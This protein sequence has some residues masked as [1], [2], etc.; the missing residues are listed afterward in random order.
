MSNP[1]YHHEI[2]LFTNLNVVRNVEILQK[3]LTFQK[4]LAS[5]SMNIGLRQAP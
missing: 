4:F 2:N 1:A 3:F 5:G